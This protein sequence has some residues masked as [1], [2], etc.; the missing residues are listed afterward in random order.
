MTHDFGR[1]QNLFDLFEK[2]LTD[3]FRTPFGGAVDDCVEK[4]AS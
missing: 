3:G 2:G 4:P 1:K